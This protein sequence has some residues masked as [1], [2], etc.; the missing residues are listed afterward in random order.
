LKFPE[1]NNE[2]MLDFGAIRVGDIKDSFF[3]VKNTGL[4]KV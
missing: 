1:N 2:N 3:T 4:Y